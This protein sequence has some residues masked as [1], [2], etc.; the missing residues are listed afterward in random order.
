MTSTFQLSTFVLIVA[1]A[2]NGVANGTYRGPATGAELRSCCAQSKSVVCLQELLELMDV[3]LVE[4]D[5]RWKSGKLQACG[6]SSQ[7]VIHVVRALFEDTDM[8]RQVLHTVA[9]T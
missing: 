6:F 5:D 4:I 9:S 2:A 7:E 8:R 3:R 1:F